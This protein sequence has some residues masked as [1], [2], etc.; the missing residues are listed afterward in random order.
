VAL[1]VDVC[2]ADWSQS[3]ALDVPTFQTAL[4]CSVATASQLV[5]QTN[6]QL[7]LAGAVD[8]CRTA[9]VD[10]V[11]VQAFASWTSTRCRRVLQ[12]LL[13]QRAGPERALVDGF[14]TLLRF[15][16]TEA[17]LQ[18]AHQMITTCGWWLSSAR[19]WA[20]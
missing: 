20:L 11:L 15:G 17:L 12:S 3:I 1:A 14:H 7:Q 4:A 8:A 16:W 13:V 5:A 10:G 18:L 2:L 9:C 6:A 19:V